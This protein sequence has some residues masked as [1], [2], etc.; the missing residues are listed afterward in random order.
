MQYNDQKLVWIVIQVNTEV[1]R[2]K[3]NMHYSY[4]ALF[5]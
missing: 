4:M 2:I 5:K 1:L 3:G